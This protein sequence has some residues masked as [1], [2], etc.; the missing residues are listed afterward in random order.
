MNMTTI[1]F[2][3]RLLVIFFILIIHLE[4]TSPAMA[5]EAVQEPQCLTQ[6]KWTGTSWFGSPIIHDLG[7]GAPKLIGTFYDIFVWDSDFNQLARAPSGAS[8]P[9]EGRIYPPAVC[10]DL[11]QDGVFEIVVG[12]NKGKVAAYEWKDNT[13]TPKAGW[14]ASTCDAGQCPEVRGIAG[15]DLDGDGIIEIVA[16]TTQTAGGAQVYVFNTDFGRGSQRR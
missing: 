16:T 4:G 3:G 7:E 10:A 11:E 13:L 12:S 8:Y 14:P 1:N 6:I 5:S 9:H 15:G 2:A